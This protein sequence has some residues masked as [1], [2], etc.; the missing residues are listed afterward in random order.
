MLQTELSDKAMQ[1]GLGEILDEITKM[2]AAPALEIN[3]KMIFIKVVF[4]GNYE[5]R[6]SWLTQWEIGGEK[7]EWDIW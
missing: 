5:V 4:G 2:F 7:Y 6:L 3:K 1:S